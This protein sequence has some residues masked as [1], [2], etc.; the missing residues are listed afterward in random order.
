MSKHE[1]NLHDAQLEMEQDGPVVAQEC[2]PPPEATPGHAA[3]PVATPGSATDKVGLQDF[4]LL[5]LVGQG[6]F[7]KV[8]EVSDGRALKTVSQNFTVC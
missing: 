2:P 6:A 3:A 1:E 5:C 8:R 7:G 4:E